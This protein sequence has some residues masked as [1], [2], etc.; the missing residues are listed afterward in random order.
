[1]SIS[2]NC[3]A[4]DKALGLS[5]RRPSSALPSHRKLRSQALHHL[6]LSGRDAN[7]STKPPHCSAFPRPSRLSEAAPDRSPDLSSS[8][9]L[10]S[11]PTNARLLPN[12]HAL[13]SLPFENVCSQ[14]GC[15]PRVPV[16]C[17]R[18]L[19]DDLRRSPSVMGF[20]DIYPIELEHLEVDK[21][22]IC[23]S[24]RPVPPP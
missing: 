18:S 12:A 21:R 11:T 1:M 7:L 13:S 6:H 17:T 10:S 16:S 3:G 19:A 9:V 4:T 14:P 8:G 24:S 22:P 23:R 15:C 20:V 5:L 2:S